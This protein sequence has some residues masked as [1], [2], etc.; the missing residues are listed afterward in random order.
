MKMKNQF[1]KYY[2]TIFLL[3]SSFILF[4]EP[5]AGND[6]NDLESI[7]APAASINDY[8]WILAVVGVVFAFY[9]FKKKR[10][11]SFIVL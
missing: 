1:K 9:F 2:T 4:A 11:K 10:E 8:L 6:T 7:D 5:G 3:C